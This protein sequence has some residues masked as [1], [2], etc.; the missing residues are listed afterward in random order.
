MEVQRLLTQ[1]EDITADVVRD[2]LGKAAGMKPNV[3]HKPAKMSDRKQNKP[4]RKNQPWFD[5][6]CLTLKKEISTSV[7]LYQGKDIL[8][9]KDLAKSTEKKQKGIQ[10]RN[11]K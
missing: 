6:D 7:D 11:H 8:S 10:D 9:Q 1:P 3:T 2:L 5:D 4:K